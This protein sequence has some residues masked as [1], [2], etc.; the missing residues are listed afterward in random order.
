MRRRVDRLDDER[1]REQFGKLRSDGRKQAQKSQPQRSKSRMII[2]CG[3]AHRDAFRRVLDETKRDEVARFLL[4]R[5]RHLVVADPDLVHERRNV[6]VVKGKFASDHGVEDDAARP[7][8]GLDA[9]VGE[10]LS[11]WTSTGGLAWDPALDGE[12]EQAESTGSHV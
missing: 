6:V 10:T 9:V 12:A 4:D 3:R 2:S 8:V 5:E 7:G 1:V 11:R